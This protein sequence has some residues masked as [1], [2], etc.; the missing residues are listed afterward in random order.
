MITSINII[1]QISVAQCKMTWY[2]S[3]VLT[4]ELVLDDVP[5]SFGAMQRN[6][7]IKLSSNCREFIYDPH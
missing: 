2:S 1:D 6:S 4:M 7:H 5:N 3:C